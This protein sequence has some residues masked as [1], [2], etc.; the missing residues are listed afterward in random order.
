M[1]QMRTETKAEA[2]NSIFK[3]PK[4]QA[5][6]RQGSVQVTS[7]QPSND[8]LTTEATKAAFKSERQ[9]GNC[10]KQKSDLK[11]D[12][13]RQKNFQASLMAASMQ[14]L[15]IQEAPPTIESRSSASSCQNQPECSSRLPKPSNTSRPQE[16]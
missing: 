12:V 14:S 15:R 4:M 6:K 3:Q 10:E 9:V 5:S 8:L 7:E 11:T 2:S 13:L 16:I 1:K